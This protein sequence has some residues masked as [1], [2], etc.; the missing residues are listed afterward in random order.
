M[1][2]RI[3]EV[4]QL[5]RDLPQLRDDELFINYARKGILATE[6]DLDFKSNL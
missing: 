5:L 2:E 6:N 3:T 4:A 1:E